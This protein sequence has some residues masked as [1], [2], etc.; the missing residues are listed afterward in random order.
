MKIVFFAWLLPLLAGCATTSPS[1]SQRTKDNSSIEIDYLRGQNHH[2]FVATSTQEFAQV[3]MFRDRTLT[4]QAKIEREKYGELLKQAETLL[5]F[6]P[7]P[8][9]LE[10]CRTP[11]VLKINR[12]S[13]TKKMEGCRSA[14]EGAAVGKLIR[15]V[16]FLVSSK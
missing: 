5:E 7:A 16:E 4:K 8:K 10:L 13:D 9:G 11:F 15:D 2:R 14:E 1:V 12:D 6:Q 3:E